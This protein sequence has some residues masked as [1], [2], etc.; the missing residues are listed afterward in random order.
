MLSAVASARIRIIEK[1]SSRPVFSMVPSPMSYQKIW[2]GLYYRL[3][4]SGIGAVLVWLS[5]PECYG[6]MI[7][8]V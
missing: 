3:S 5:K 4:W 6:L 2:Q 8:M 1:M 7:T